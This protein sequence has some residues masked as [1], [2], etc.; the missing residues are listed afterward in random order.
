MSTKKPIESEMIAV[1]PDSRVYLEALES[2]SLFEGEPGQQQLSRSVREV[3]HGLHHVLAGGTVSVKI[4]SDGTSSIVD[5]LETA[6]NNAG[7]GT[8]GG[9]TFAETGVHCP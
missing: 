4:Q 3:L 5:E 1:T 8:C 6:L 9:A 2:Y 7:N